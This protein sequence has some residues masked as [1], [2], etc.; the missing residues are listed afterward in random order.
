MLD[1]WNSPLR[2]AASKLVRSPAG[3]LAA[4]ATASLH[5]RTPVREL[6]AWFGALQQVRVPRGVVA[7]VRPTPA[8]SAN[9]RILLDLLDATRGIEG[10]VAE[11]GVYRGATL[12]AMALHLDR[13]A[14]PRHLFGFDSFEGFGE[15]IEIDLILGG[16][17]DLRKHPGGFA[18]TSVSEVWQRA[19]R[20]GV[21]G[22]VSLEVGW[23][24][25]SLAVARDEQFSFVHL[26]CDLY[27]SYRG[28]LE[29]FYPRLAKGGIVLLDEYDDPPWPGCNRAV[30][31]FPAD[32]G[33]TLVEI[34]RDN[35]IKY[36]FR[37]E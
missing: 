13:T 28:C 24:P 23:L 27:E 22:R 35:H 29:F 25:E 8:G 9:V 21:E 31:E 14:S 7:P 10:H 30:D 20:L 5:A 2:R 4:D 11:C 32:R 16:S 34:Q 1:R 15:R 26:D 18:S 19:R 37:R 33:E 6:P 17:A 36:Y 3:T 12:L